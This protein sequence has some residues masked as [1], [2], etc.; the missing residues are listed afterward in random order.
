MNLW[1]DLSIER[2]QIVRAGRHTCISDLTNATRW[3]SQLADHPGAHEI[4]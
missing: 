2:L 1:M 4:S 3:V